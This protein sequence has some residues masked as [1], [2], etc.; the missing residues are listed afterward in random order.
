MVP[1]SA[2]GNPITGLTA[3]G[4]AVTYTLE[5][6]KGIAYATFDATTA[7]YVVTYLSP[8]DTTITAGPTGTTTS[9]NATFQFTSNPAGAT[10]QCSLDGASFA[11]C[12]SPVSY[13]GLTNGS[14]TFRVRAVGAGGPDATPAVRTWT[15]SAPVPDT[16][17][18]AGPSGT[19]SSQAATFQFTSNPTGAAFQCSL[20]GASFATCVSGIAYS[21]LA[22]GSHTFQVRAVNT[23]GADATPATRTWTVDTTAPVITNVVATPLTTSATITWTTNEASD[24]VVNYGTSASSLTQTATVSTMVTAHSVTLNSL[25]AGRTYFYRVTSRNA[26][27]LT[28]SSPATSASFVTRTAVTQAPGTAT[29]TAGTLRSGSAGNLSS[30]NGSYYQVNSTTSG[31]RTSTWYGSFTGV[32]QALANLR[33]NYSGMQSRTV[34]QNIEIFQWTTNTWVLLNTR[35][36]GTTETLVSNLAPSGSAASYVSASGEVRV[37]VRSVGSSTSFFTTADL[38]QISFDRP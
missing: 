7:A 27:G 11:T 18:T 13:S 2:N 25:T 16:T 35:S 38:L 28:A 12:V 21:G 32:S 19:T 26:A 10:F 15:V 33:V 8:P 4:N 36:V 30:N 24:S 29:I 6:I 1:A 17:I 5:T 37:R 34:T 23:A 14:H 22:A 31:T 9:P 3:D 20:D